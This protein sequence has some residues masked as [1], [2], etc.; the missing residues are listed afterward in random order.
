MPCEIIRP[1]DRGLPCFVLP[2]Y[3]DAVE[4]FYPFTRLPEPDTSYERWKLILL[5]MTIAPLRLLMLCIVL[6]FGALC[7]IIGT[8]NYDPTSIDNLIAPLPL[9]RRILFTMARYSGRSGLFL[10]GFHR[11][12]INELS[13]KEMKDKFKYVP[14]VPIEY[15][16]D[17][18]EIHAKC[19]VIV[20]NHLGFADIL[21]LLW[22]C[23]GSFLAKEAMRNVTGIGTIC[24]A[25]QSIF[26]SKNKSTTECLV[27][28]VKLS[29]DLNQSGCG[30]GSSLSLSN[31][32]VFPEGTTTNGNDLIM[33]RRG[34][35]TAG[36]PV[37]P[38]IIKCKW[39]SCNTSWETIYFRHLTW[40]VLTQFV[41]HMEVIMGPPYIPTEA[42]KKDSALYAFNV[43]I[44]MAQ[45][46]G[47]NNEGRKARIYLTNRN[48]KVK[49]Y[50]Q[51]YLQG[52]DKDTV[53]QLARD[54]IK[55]DALIGKYL[56]MLRNDKRY[57]YG[58][59]DQEDE[60]SGEEKENCYEYH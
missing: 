54:K 53:M 39:K 37:R 49:C 10:Y 7:G 14:P 29:H 9:W 27:E 59:D 1:R 11:L 2:D 19:N 25:M 57:E 34:I 23:N 51:Q 22:Y 26:V 5:S 4:S 48:V 28:R 6:F 44:L 18:E 17:G 8:I 3:E 40:E 43:N 42:E 45:M 30:E 50:H 21:F 41:N 24:A 56:E 60:G 31:M 38:I 20:S 32:C 13:Y 16:D 46:M 47:I 55:N 15:D 12:K 58:S 35:F 52:M 36:L 33:F